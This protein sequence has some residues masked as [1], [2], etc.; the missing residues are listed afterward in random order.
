M[1]RNSPDLA[2]KV[3]GTLI[4]VAVGSMISKALGKHPVAGAV[5]AFVLTAVV[6]P[7]IVVVASDIGF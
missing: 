1:S 3:V 2:A 5:V 6:T 7:E 4:V